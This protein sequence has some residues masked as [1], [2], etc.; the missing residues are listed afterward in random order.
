MKKNILWIALILIVV[1]VVAWGVLSAQSSGPV[2]VGVAAAVKGEVQVTASGT[3]ARPLKSKDKV[4]MGDKIETGADGQLQVL[5]FDETVFTLGPSSTSTVDEFVYDPATDDGKVKASMLKG[6][7]RVVSGKVAH[8]QPENMSVGLPAGTIG[9]RG[10]IVGGIITGQQSLIALLGSA[11]TGAGRIYVSNVVNGNVVGVDITQGGYGTIIGGP[12][13]APLPVFQVPAADIQKIAAA[14]GQTMTQ[15]VAAET[16]GQETTTVS[17][18]TD[19]NAQTTEN[20]L[21]TVD[22][23]DKLTQQAAQDKADSSS[24]SSHSSGGGY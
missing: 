9:F 2:Q 3:A 15:G 13:I 8:K 5:L 7:F 23:M 12:N 21:S 19:T 1:L 18:R 20:L 11:Q 10:T 4:F 24:S 6:I 22:K 17:R 16:T 14:V